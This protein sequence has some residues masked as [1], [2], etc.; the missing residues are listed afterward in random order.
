ME[1]IINKRQVKSYKTLE[2]KYIHRKNIEKSNT[3]NIEV[4]KPKKEEKRST[5]SPFQLVVIKL[6]WYKRAFRS[7]LGF[8]GYYYE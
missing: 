3:E 8:L 5:I 7:L 6:P 4:E 1:E 2:N